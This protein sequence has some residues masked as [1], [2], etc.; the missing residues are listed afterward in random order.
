L[1]IID[2]NNVR[3]ALECVHCGVIYRSYQHWYGNVDPEQSSVVVTK[4]HHVWPGVSVKCFYTVAGLLYNEQLFLVYL[5][6]NF[7]VCTGELWRNTL[8]YSE[9]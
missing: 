9:H 6:T 4:I 2:Y 1:I 8:T 3:Y 5:F 7:V